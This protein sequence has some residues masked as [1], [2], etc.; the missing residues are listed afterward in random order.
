M[1]RKGR[2]CALIMA[3]ALA[4]TGFSACNSQGGENSS[5]T[6]S[7][8]SAQGSSDTAAA[9]TSDEA[10]SIHYLSARGAQEGTMQSLQKLRTSIK[11][12]IL[13]LLMRQRLLR[14]VPL[15]CKSSEFLLPAM[16][17]R[18]G[19]IPTRIPSSPNWWGRMR[20]RI[21][22]LCTMSWVLPMTFTQSPRT[23]S[24]CQTAFWD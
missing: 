18:I 4:C 2:L 8:S 9:D 10:L 16:N 5:S 22:A 6:E 20:L 23:I 15:I 7:D 21:S 19:L 17:C 1:R 14:I 13:I 24:V 11:K 3:L 12:L